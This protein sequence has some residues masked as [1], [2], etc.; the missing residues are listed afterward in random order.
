[1]E[2]YKMKPAVGPYNIIEQG[3]QPNN[4]VENMTH[5]KC[6]GKKYLRFIYKRNRYSIYRR[7]LNPYFRV[8]AAALSDGRNGD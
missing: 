3:R 2:V 6:C 5:F 7:N 4:S 1:M 8:K